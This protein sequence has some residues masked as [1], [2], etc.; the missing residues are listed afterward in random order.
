V[1]YI[2]AQVELVSNQISQNVSVVDRGEKGL[3]VELNKLKNQLSGYKIESEIRKAE[4]NLASWMSAICNELDFEDRFMPAKLRMKLTDLNVFHDDKKY[5][6]V[7]L[8]DMG[9]GANWLAFHLSASLAMLRL[10]AESER[11]SVP[12]F[13]FIDQP[14][15]VYFPRE[16]TA[17]DGDTKNVANIYIQLLNYLRDVKRATKCYPQI[18]VLD[19]ASDLNLGDYYFDRYLRKDWHDGSALI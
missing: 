5:K 18:I 17:E 16:F 9:S 12:A 6:K 8:S 2:K 7:S 3:R 1:H 15:Q 10:F 13:L 19:H 11:S 4:E 14:S